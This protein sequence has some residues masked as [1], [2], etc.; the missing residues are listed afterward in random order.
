MARNK[1]STALFEVIHSD[2]RYRNAHGAESKT[3]SIL[4]TPKWWFRGRND[5]TAPAEQPTADA[6]QAD[7]TLRPPAIPADTA[8]S[9]PPPASVPAPAPMPAAADRAAAVEPPTVV[10]EPPRAPEPEP[11]RSP[12]QPVAAPVARAKVE[13]TPEPE[14]I[15]TSS[16]SLVDPTRP[17]M[18]LGRAGVQWMADAQRRIVTLR[19]RYDTA[20]VAAAAITL[21]VGLAYVI[22][23]HSG[24]G[25]SQS[26]TSL[27]TA[28]IK[29]G[30]V[31]P[32][33]LEVGKP[34]TSGKPIAQAPPVRET[35]ED[36]I[37]NTLARPETATG[38]GAIQSH[39]LPRQVSL[40]YVVIQ[41]Y[42]D[43]QKAQEAC[44]LLVANGIDCTIEYSL[45]R[46]H[47]DWYSV[48]GTAGFSRISSS[49]Y[50]QYMQKIKTVGELLVRSHRGMKPLQPTGYKWDRV[51]HG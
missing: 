37:G 41:S 49:E 24:K 13:A 28:A 38:G 23:R 20:M 15:Q 9:P 18:H 34:A 30:P 31:Q 35:R 2:K 42:T 47:E 6:L 27:S 5:G 7:P 12:P 4:R 10:V 14:E 36:L 50:E 25:T 33:V 44:E 51:D 29:E 43:R 39:T 32:D 19:L 17:W 40:N 3:K 8:V 48:V 46:F 16:L 45:P 11:L 21:L 1:Y 22:G 26:Y